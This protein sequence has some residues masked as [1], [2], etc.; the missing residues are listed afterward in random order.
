VSSANR[1][2]IMLGC[3]ANASDADVLSDIPDIC[4]SFYINLSERI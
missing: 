2:P 3:C 1:L 4:P